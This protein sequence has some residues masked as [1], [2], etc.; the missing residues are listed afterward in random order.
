MVKK[1]ENWKSHCKK[2][3]SMILLITYLCVLVVFLGAVFVVVGF[4][5]LI[6]WLKRI[7]RSH[8]GENTPLLYEQPEIQK[9]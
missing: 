9:H 5:T 6:A 1:Q 2:L 7:K 4:L 3:I 8:R